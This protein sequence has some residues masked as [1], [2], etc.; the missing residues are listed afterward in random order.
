MIK[1]LHQELKDLRSKR[2]QLYKWM[3][4]HTQHP[5]FVK[6]VSDKNHLTVKIQAIE[7][8]I[9]QLEANEPIL[10]EPYGES[11]LNL[12]KHHHNLTN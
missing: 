6:I 10:G 11:T 1:E 5:D 8:K 12:E 4:E 3:C 2:D 7:F 9:S